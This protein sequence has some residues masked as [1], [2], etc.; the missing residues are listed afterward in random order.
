MKTLRR[1][2]VAGVLGSLGVVAARLEACSVPVFRYAL[3]QWPAQRYE[4]TVFHRGPLGED[5]RKVVEWLSKYADAQEPAANLYVRTVDLD[6]KADEKALELWKAQQGA[7]TPLMAL[8][9]PE[10]FGT[11][12]TAW[13]GSLGAA[14]AKAVVDSPA[15]REI[16]KRILSGESAVWVLLECG[17]PKKDDAAAKVLDAEL[18]KLK[19]TLELPEILQEDVDRG[20]AAAVGLKVD[21]S[22]LRLSRS[23]PAEKVFIRMLLGSEAKLATVS[24]P[25]A[26]PVFGQGRALCGVVGDEIN[27]ENINQIGEFLVGPCS[28]I[29]KEQNPGVDLLMSVDWEGGLAEGRWVKPPEL[30]A[31][32][33]PEALVQQARDAGEKGEATSRPAAWRALTP[34][35]FGI[36]GAL[37]VVLAAV[38]VGTVVLLRRR[39]SA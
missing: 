27:A 13:T 10:S 16:A 32:T 30:P 24:E 9:Y 2:L 19:E 18:R 23:D 34:L 36:A 35:G 5:Q 31:L 17:D 28:C 1:V 11:A 21:F 8:T 22:L 7:S 3:E 25:I 6:G 38:V 14:E 4:L 15:R 26:L 29:V 33:G 12:E 39:K 20:A 37:L